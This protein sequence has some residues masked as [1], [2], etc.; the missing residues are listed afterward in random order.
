[1]SA[2]PQQLTLAAGKA[3]VNLAV[4]PLFKSIE[5]KPKLGMAAAPQWQMV[6]AT[7]AADE[8]NGWELCHQ[9]MTGGLGVA[10]GKVEFAE[11]DLEQRWIIGTDAQSLMAATAT[12]ERAQDPDSRLPT[13]DGFFW[14]RDDTH[15]QLQGARDEVGP[16]GGCATVRARWHRLN[17]PGLLRTTGVGAQS[18]LTFSSSLNCRSS[19]RR[20][21]R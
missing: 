10:G 11:P 4:E 17:Q 19:Y 21:S 6:S 20:V 9:I 16:I 18:L 15:S 13:G 14:F 7:E 12:C 5:E 1:M 8:V 2:G 3:Q